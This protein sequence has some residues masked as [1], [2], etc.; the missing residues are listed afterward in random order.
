MDLISDF[1]KGE[2][3]TDGEVIGLVKG[4][5][6]L[7]IAGKESI[8]FCLKQGWISEDDIVKIKKI[9]HTQS[10]FVDD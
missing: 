1:Y 9:P 10:L 6:I 3:K 7:N 4:A 8:D 5:Y 2:E